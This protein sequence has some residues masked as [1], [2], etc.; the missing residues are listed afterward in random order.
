[1][2]Y[3]RKTTNKAITPEMALEAKR[4]EARNA[5]RCDTGACETGV[6]ETGVCEN[7]TRGTSVHETGGSAIL[8]LEDGTS[9]EGQ[10]CGAK[11]EA[12]GEICFNT[13][14]IGY[15]EIIS[16]PAYAGSILV[17]TYPQIGNYGIARED[18]ECDRA[19]LRGLVVR[20]ICHT[21]SNFRSDLSL[22]D[23]LVEQ[24]IVALSGIDTRSLLKYAWGTKPIWAL[25]S[26]EESHPGILQTRL[27]EY[28]KTAGKNL[29][30]EVS[31]RLPWDSEL[32]E[33]TGSR[34]SFASQV[35]WH[36]PYPVP[37]CRVVAIDCG[38]TRSELR[39]LM[40]AACSITLLPWDSSVDAIMSHKPDG[41]FISGGPGH[42][43]APK[44][45]LEVLSGLMGQIPIFGT[46]LGHQLIAL[47][48]GGRV[49]PM[50]APH[51]GANHPVLELKTRTVSATK[52]HHRYTV[53]FASLGAR[54][55]A[56]TGVVNN[57]RY[58]RIQ[59]TH[60]HADDKFV[61]GLR[62]LDIPIVS[63][64]FDP[65]FLPDAAGPHPLYAEFVK[66]M[67]AWA[68]EPPEAP[69]EAPAKGFADERAESASGTEADHA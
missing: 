60:I 50:R 20:D 47:A 23:Y 25:L 39:H 45:T 29:V 52:Q 19:A 63:A 53:D 61:E 33:A 28:K 15:P 54:E 5:E 68:K 11:G 10:S 35:A 55:V 3:T 26:T 48:A 42:P 13:A 1:M 6:W 9:F 43:E 7:G 57:E 51:F 14:M 12:C 24:G 40:R 30:A 36:A 69:V 65:A 49:E 64:Q 18:L 34:H 31:T 59:L 62:F 4:N 37:R 66:M 32:G 27:L 58:G 67:E 44:V 2:I 38:I 21:P 8:V 46:G 41:I 22:P 17:M 56:S 16:D